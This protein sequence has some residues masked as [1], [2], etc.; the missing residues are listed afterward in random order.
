MKRAFGLF[1]LLGFLGC[2]LPLAFGYSLFDMRGAD[3]APFW[4]I[5]AAFAVP[6]VIG[7]GDKLRGL[8]ALAAIGCFG[9]LLIWK[10][11]FDTYDLVVHAQ[12]G[13]K[14]IGFAALG[15][16]ITSVLSLAEAK[17]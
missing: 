7:F 9:Y 15:G 3:G 6:M 17:D 11:G 4:T 10:F 13:G 14:A 1:A 5:L 2:F 16:F 12:S 8:S